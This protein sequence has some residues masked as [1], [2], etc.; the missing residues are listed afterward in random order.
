MGRN[1][2]PANFALTY[3]SD[4][5]VAPSIQ[6]TYALVTGFFDALKSRCGQSAR[7]KCEELTAND[8][9]ASMKKVIYTEGNIHTCIR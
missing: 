7:S 6:A 8:L 2:C 9:I 1:H 5:L 3:E 4:S